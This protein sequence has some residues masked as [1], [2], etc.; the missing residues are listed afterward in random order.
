MGPGGIGPGLVFAFFVLVIYG[1]QV[2]MVHVGQLMDTGN[3]HE[4]L[5]FIIVPFLP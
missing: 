4:T 5:L 1:K 3:L 2:Q